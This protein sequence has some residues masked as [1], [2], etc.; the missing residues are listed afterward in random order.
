MRWTE[1]ALAKVQR[2]N[3]SPARKES[4]KVPP[5]SIPLA[6]DEFE[7]PFLTA[8]PNTWSRM[9]WASRGRQ[10]KAVAQLVFAMYPRFVGLRL[11]KARI[12]VV[13]YSSSEPDPDAKGFVKPILDALQV[14]SKRHPYGTGTI[15]DDNSDCVQLVTLWRQHPPGHGRMVVKVEPIQ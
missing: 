9:H 6:E 13:R 2:R 8:L 10:T 12:T 3:K 11:A 1:S 15:V 14:A 7:I 5:P 4:R